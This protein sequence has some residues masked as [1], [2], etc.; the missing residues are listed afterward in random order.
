MSYRPA[1]SRQGD[2]PSGTPARHRF[3][4]HWR[5]PAMPTSVSSARPWTGAGSA[6]PRRSSADGTPGGRRG[7][8]GPPAKEAYS[9]RYGS[10]LTSRTP[11]AYAG[12][13]IGVSKERLASKAGAPRLLTGTSSATSTPTCAVPVSGRLSA[14]TGDT[15]V[16]RPKPSSLVGSPAPRDQQRDQRVRSDRARRCR[17]P[18]DS[19]LPGRVA[20]P[21]RSAGRFSVVPAVASRP[22]GVAARRRRGAVPTGPLPGGRG[23]L[24]SSGR[25]RHHPPLQRIDACRS[26][27]LRPPRPRG[28]RPGGWRGWLG[29]GRRLVGSDARPGPHLGLAGA[30][31][32]RSRV[33]SWAGWSSMTWCRPT[34][35][36]GR[37]PGFSPWPP[38]LAS[39]VWSPSV[40]RCQGGRRTAG[41][42]C[43]GTSATAT[44]R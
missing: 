17:G 42:S 23:P 6:G 41:S 33:P 1:S 4:A 40:T 15:W 8:R 28:G 13:P 39:G 20:V 18:P 16:S 37:W 36:R 24:R 32:R 26:S 3:Q 29:R 22:P 21:R 38:T 10:T 35:N 11:H 9:W 31:P 5:S 12:S 19:R 7:R 30:S 27:L 34:P 43:P 2:S 25:L 44:R 14:S